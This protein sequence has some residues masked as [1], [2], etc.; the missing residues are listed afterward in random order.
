[1]PVFNFNQEAFEKKREPAEPA[2]S[3]FPLSRDNG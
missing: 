1:M 3:I 2:G